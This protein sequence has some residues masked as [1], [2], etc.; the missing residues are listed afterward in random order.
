MLG[1]NKQKNDLIFAKYN[2]L[3]QKYMKM[4]EISYRPVEIPLDFFFEELNPAFSKYYRRILY[5]ITE[6]SGRVCLRFFC[7]CWT[8]FQSNTLPIWYGSYGSTANNFHTNHIIWEVFYLETE[9]PVS[10]HRQTAANL[11]R[12][13]CSTMVYHIKWPI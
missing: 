6:L 1:S 3:L 10:G 13:F 4:V 9:L 12:D 11:F 2:K 5:S 7:V 8:L